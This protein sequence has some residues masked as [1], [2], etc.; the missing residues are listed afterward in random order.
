MINTDLYVIFIPWK[1]QLKELLEVAEKHIVNPQSLST[2]KTWI[3]KDKFIS[4]TYDGYIYP[5]KLEVKNF[6]G[7][8]FIYENNSFIA[9]LRLHEFEN[10]LKV[11]YNNMPEILDVDLKNIEKYF[12]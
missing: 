6:V 2:D 5:L 9:N 3:A 8:K 1:H 11:L 12:T 10:C 4:E 7:Y